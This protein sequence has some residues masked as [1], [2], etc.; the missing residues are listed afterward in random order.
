MKPRT[1]DVTS[2]PLHGGRPIPG[3][4]GVIE[5]V[6]KPVWGTGSD[7]PLC[8]LIGEAPG[9]DEE[10]YGVPFVGKSG[11]ELTMYLTRFSHITRDRCWVTNLIKCRPPKNRDPHKEEI[12][13]CIRHYLWEE[14]E[15]TMPSII[16]T[17]GRIATQHFLGNVTM[18]KVHGIPQPGN[19]GCTVG[20]F[21][22]VPLYHPAYGLHS[23]RQMKDV[24]E[25]FTA[26]GRV[27]RGQL[28][29]RQEG[30]MELDYKLEEGV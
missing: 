23:P 21:V 10:S 11:Q 13:Y 8:M 1:C 15:H 17:V 19:Y 29:P 27:I 22:V 26:L 25:D 14:I 2:C 6:S 24:I 7:S 18:E 9:A 16:G 30:E 3:V 28:K 12:D 5:K 4:K 20:D